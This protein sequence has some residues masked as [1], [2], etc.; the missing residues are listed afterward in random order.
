MIS[1]NKACESKVTIITLPLK[2]IPCRVTIK[3][4]IETSYLQYDDEPQ[5]KMFSKQSQ[6]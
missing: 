6:K 4:M 2:A 3:R 5:S 1:Y